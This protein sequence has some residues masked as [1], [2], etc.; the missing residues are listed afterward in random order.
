MKNNYIVIKNA[1]LHNLKNISLKI[2]K[3]SLTVITGPSGSGKSSLAFDTIY[4]EG[5]RRYIESLSSYARQ[6]LGQYQAPEVESITGL[7]PTIAIDQK[8]VNRNPRSTV[9]TIT[10]IYDYLRVLFARIGNLHC[11]K[12]KLLITKFSPTQI[13]NDLYKKYPQKKIVIS[14]LLNGKNKQELKNNF[15]KYLQQGF[16]KLIINNE[17]SN[18]ENLDK[19]SLNTSNNHYL[20]IDRVIT[21][22]NS[23]KRITDSIEL[24]LNKGSGSI[25]IYCE[26]QFLF[27]SQK[28]ISPETK[29]EFPDLTP[30]IFS[31]NSP[32]GACVKCNGLGE[33]KSFDIELLVLDSNLSINEGAIP[34]I[35]KKNSFLYKMIQDMSHQENVNINGPLSSHSKDFINILFNGSQKKYHYSFKSKNSNFQF[36]KRFPGILNWL[37]KKFL[38]TTSEKTRKNLEK[39]MRIK[40]CPQCMGNRLNNTALSTYINNHNIIDLSKMSIDEIAGFFEKLKLNSFKTKVAG[41]LIKEINNRLYF[42][43]NV[44]LEYLTLQRKSSTLSGGES[45]RIR[46]ATQIG[47]SLSGVIYVLDEPSIGLHQKDNKKLIKTLKSLRDIGNTILVVEHDEETILSADHIIDMGPN[48]GTQGGEIVVSGNLKQILKHKKSKTSLYLCKK[49]IILG[50]NTK[51]EFSDWILLKGANENNLNNINVKIP[52]GVMTCITGVSGSGKSTLI[53]SILVPAVKKYLANSANKI[54]YSKNNYLSLSGIDKIKTIIELDQSPIGRT[55]QSNPA[56]YTGIFTDI[57]TLFANTPEAKIRGY[58]PG[59]FSFNVKGGRCENC[60]GNGVIKIEMHFLPDVFVTCPECN[61]TRYNSETLNILFKSLNINEILNL[62]VSEAYS[63]LINH[64]R[65][66]RILQTMLDVGLGYLKL[67]QSATTLSGGEAQRLKLSRELSKRT[68]GNCLYVLDEP[69]TGLHFE[70]VNVLL[71]SLHSLVNNGHTCIII[72]HNLDVIKTADYIIDLG[73]GGGIN[74]GNIVA[75]GS[76]KEII[77]VLVF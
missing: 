63:F 35:Q 13:I 38:E 27:Y 65:L 55:P 18:I 7:S 16:T 30:Q 11:P 44:G 29:V 64:T 70:D 37:E 32:I 76:P 43:I 48:A 25:Y 46:L 28:L 34:V 69:T 3:N 72:E 24:A 75:E 56:T 47:S 57:R 67:G 22:E 62:T 59:R 31:F 21:K 52:L 8:S 61:G 50:N 17:I 4:A 33:T 41:N 66:K 2:P 5:Q 77:K 73:P 68:K 10:E 45:Q 36:S 9:G 19:F 58:K 40:I 20:V 39:Y 51:R 74:G 14:I 53:H 12:S 54:I 6:F 26:N 71:N 23:K 15:S 1:R 60:E 42:L 49:N